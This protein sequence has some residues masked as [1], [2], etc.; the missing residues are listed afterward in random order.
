MSQKKLPIKIALAPMAGITDSAFRI[1]NMLGGAD[2]LYSEMAH[3]NALSHGGKKT[4][5][6]LS[7]DEREE[8]YIVQIFGN[9]PECFKKAV[10]EIEKN[11]VPQKN[12]QP[13]KNSTSKIILKI[14]NR[15]SGSETDDFIFFMKNFEKFNSKDVF[16][17]K[18]KRI[19]PSG[20]DI[21]L[22]CPAKKVFLHGSGAA[23]FSDQKK[24]YTILKTVLENTKLPVSVKIRIA[25]GQVSALDFFSNIAT[26]P[27]KRIMI[28]GRSLTQGFSGEI[29]FQSLEEL[30]KKYPDRELWINGGI[31]SL[32][33]AKKIIRTIGISRLGI[34][35]G[36]WGNPLLSCRIKNDID[37]SSSD[38]NV[39]K[40][41]SAILS[42]IHANLNYQSK[43]ERGILEIRK[44]LAWYFKDFN[45]AKELRKKLVTVKNIEELETV[46]GKEVL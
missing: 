30:I 29:D 40:C 41:Q 25:V 37:S 39:R 10:A 16:R 45:G 2:L 34:A 14:L 6:L 22:G 38:E 15:I 21:N 44:H 17:E 31:N 9:D 20:I 5:E 18:I 19:K 3:V 35:R 43:G 33:D 46:L 11:G 24:T 7:A 8:E 13:I 27:L 12:Y 1:M 28:H 36:S 42:L 23:L 4:F 26:L 32:A